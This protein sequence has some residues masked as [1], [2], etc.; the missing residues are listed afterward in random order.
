[1][2]E[3]RRTVGR[4]LLRTGGAAALVLLAGGCDLLHWN[5]GARAARE[6]PPYDEVLNRWL[7]RSETDLINSWGVPARSQLL[8]GGGQVLEYVRRNGSRV[9]CSTLFTSNLTGTIERY[10]FRGT[11]CRPPTDSVAGG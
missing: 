7:G 5:N 10:S 8:S 4:R 1:M 6:G 3:G 9:S 11:D 2:R